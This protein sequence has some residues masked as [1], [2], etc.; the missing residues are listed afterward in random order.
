MH[1]ALPKVLHPLAGRLIV[2][3]VIDAVLTLSPRT[4][5]VVYGHG[6]ERVREVLHRPG[7]VFALQDPPR[8]TGDAVR[9]AL[10]SLPQ[11][12]VTMV[13]L[14]DVPLVRADELAQLA[15]VARR[16]HVGL[17]TAR[18]PDPRGLGRILRDSSGHVRAIVEERDAT[19]EQRAL[20][21][22][23]T[24]VMAMPTG[25]LVRWVGALRADNAQGEYYLTDAIA[26]AVAEGIAV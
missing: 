22:I 1:S 11:D 20:D 25:H 10:P 8:G 7:L 15:E 2:D 6:G 18:V 14:G 5:C 4:I 3:H 21:E 17:L 16:G 24:G 19:P 23:N 26:M 12:G 13:V 9:A